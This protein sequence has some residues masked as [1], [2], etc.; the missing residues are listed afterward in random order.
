[1][2]KY[3]KCDGEPDCADASDETDCPAKDEGGRR[4]KDGAAEC[5]KN[6]FMCAKSGRIKRSA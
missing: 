6:E 2:S 4:D 1:M 5:K 3:W